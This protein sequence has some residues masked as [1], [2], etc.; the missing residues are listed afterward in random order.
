MEDTQLHDCWRRN[1]ASGLSAGCSPMHV[2]WYEIH[3]QA[4]QHLYEPDSLT[5]SRSCHQPR[6]PGALAIHYD[7]GLCSHWMLHDDGSSTSALSCTLSG[8]VA[9]SPD[10][11]QLVRAHAT[12]MLEVVLASDKAAYDRTSM[13]TISSEQTPLYDIFIKAAHQA[14]RSYTR[15][16]SI[17]LSLFIRSPHS[18]LGCTP[19]LVV[20]TATA[21]L[22]RGRP[23]SE[24]QAG[25]YGRYP[26]EAGHSRWRRRRQVRLRCL[27]GRYHVHCE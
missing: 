8:L 19:S 3:F 14:P 5:R 25:G 22:T 7:R 10:W 18:R 1:M 13:T 15:Q 20:G 24:G 12:S 16:S 27:F 17:L 11:L 23:R 26:E 2:Q 6:A 9:G 21:S 4:G